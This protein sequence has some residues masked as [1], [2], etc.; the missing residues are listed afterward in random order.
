MKSTAPMPS[1]HL[2][3]TRFAVSLKRTSQAYNAAHVGA[4]LRWSESYNDDLERLAVKT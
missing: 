1:W 3:L 4:S 2:F